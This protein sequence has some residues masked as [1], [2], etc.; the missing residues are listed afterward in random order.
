[1][2]Y[3]T[4]QCSMHPRFLTSLLFFF[5]QN[6]ILH[7]RFFY[8]GWRLVCPFNVIVNC[9]WAN[10]AKTHMSLLPWSFEPIDSASVTSLCIHLMCIGKKSSKISFLN[11]CTSATSIFNSSFVHSHNLLIDVAL[12]S[13]ELYCTPTVQ[14]VEEFEP[15]VSQAVKMSQTDGNTSIGKHFFCSSFCC[16]PPVKKCIPVERPLLNE[17][18]TRSLVSEEPS[19]ATASIDLFGGWADV[20]ILPHGLLS[21]TTLFK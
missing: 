5:T 2:L 14:N 13:S 18:F 19:L 6:R 21:W 15:P 1:M 17:R 9:F 8:P 10:P 16:T 12:L 3:T 11:S 7:M 4:R 20:L